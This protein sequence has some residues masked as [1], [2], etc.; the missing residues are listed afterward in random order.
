MVYLLH[1]CFIVAVDLGATIIG[2]TELQCD[3][4]PHS[5]P[6][7]RVG[8]KNSTVIGVTNLD[9]PVTDTGLT[10][11]KGVRLPQDYPPTSAGNTYENNFYLGTPAGFDL[12]TN[13]TRSNYDACAL[14][15]N[16]SDEV[17]FEGNISTSVGTCS[18]IITIECLN[19]IRRQATDA[20]LASNA[21][22]VADTC[23]A[24][25]SDF[26]ENLSSE[27]SQYATG[28][29]WDGLRVQG[30]LLLRISFHL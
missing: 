27:C 9:D 8:D 30:T 11:T 18:D 4:G 29:K 24:L 14:F 16:F 20:V 1:V 6:L 17:E 7:C 26:S 5:N 13:A 23:K 21:S 15:F 12:S 28:E 19:A 10:W 22:S 25:E 3:P 2:C